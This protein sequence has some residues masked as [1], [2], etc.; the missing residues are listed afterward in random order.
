M[1]S[2]IKQTREVGTS[3][4]VLLPRKWLNK[5]VV[6]TLLIPSIEEIAKEVIGI[7][8]GKN[9]N[10]EVKGIYLYGS[11]ARGEND[12]DSDIDI[13]VIT[14]KTNKLINYMNYEILLVSEQDF[15]KNLSN[16]LNYL[17]ILKE[18]KVIINEEL[19]EKYSSKNIRYKG[20][21]ISEIVKIMKINKDSVEMCIKN[22][23]KIP[24]GVI[25]SIIL[26]LRELYLIKCLNLN[27]VYSKKYFVD[28]IGEKN[29]IAYNRVKRNERDLDE[30]SYNEAIK[31]LGLYEKWVKDL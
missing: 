22:N 24:D 29:Y 8:V 1:T 7:L 27:R 15:S 18:A 3:A 2:L 9:L 28:M 23:R 31:L 6:V 12:A 13:L 10:G 21:I 19:I 17:S 30:V 26:R 25:Y 16:S 20:N 4:G 11:Y 14:K 5:Q